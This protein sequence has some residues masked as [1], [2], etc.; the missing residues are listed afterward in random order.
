MPGVRPEVRTPLLTGPGSPAQASPDAQ[1][2]ASQETPPARLRAVSRPRQRKGV[3]TPDT[4]TASVERAV[5]A[6]YT[7]G[8][9]VGQLQK[10][11]KISKNSASE[12]QEE[13]A[14]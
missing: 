11:A 14:V 7:P 4:R 2:E 12:P 6:V 10:A 8:M 13:M 3:R 9:T 5:R 1:V